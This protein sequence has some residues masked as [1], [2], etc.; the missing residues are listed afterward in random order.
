MIVRVRRERVNERS[1]A[2]DVPQF[3]SFDDLGLLNE[4]ETL[5]W[6][7][8]VPFHLQIIKGRPID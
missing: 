3:R 5:P 6:S 7:S 8:A 1:L 4:Y 2:A